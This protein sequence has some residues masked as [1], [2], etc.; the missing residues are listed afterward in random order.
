MKGNP[1]KRQFQTG[2]LLRWSIRSGL[3]MVFLLAGCATP[4]NHGKS[5]LHS[6]SPSYAVPRRAAAYNRAY[7]VRGRI[8]HPLASAKGYRERGLA[9]WYGNESGD[10]TA[11]GTRFNPKGLSAA[12]RT[13]PLPTRVRITNLANRRSIIVLVND[14]G[15]FVDERLIDLSHGAAKALHLSGLGRVEIEALD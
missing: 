15:P 1:Y 14:R 11:M 5:E 12:H 3:G 4:V 9:S 7:K 8:Y 6:A 10:R 2:Q 13:L